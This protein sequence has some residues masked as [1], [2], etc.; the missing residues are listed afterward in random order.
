MYIHVP[1]DEILSSEADSVIY[2]HVCRFSSFEQMIP[3][4]GVQVLYV[5]QVGILIHGQSLRYFE[6]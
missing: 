5:A 1:Y 2:I 3:V 6:I 4:C